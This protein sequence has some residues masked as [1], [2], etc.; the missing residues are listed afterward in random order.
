MKATACGAALVLAAVVSVSCASAPEQKALDA[1]SRDFYSKVRYIITREERNTFLSLRPS[2]QPEFIKQFW[3]RRDPTPG[4]EA[5]EFKDRYFQRIDDANRLFGGGG[6]PGWLQ[7]RGRVY[8][9]LGPADRRER[10][11]KGTDFLDRPSETWWYGNYPVVFVDQDRTDDY[12]L[13]SA[14]AQ[15]L[16][17]IGRV[18]EG[19][20]ARMSAP[21][22]APGMGPGMMPGGRLE[23]PP[24]PGFT[25]AAARNGNMTE[26]AVK[27]PYRSI[28][29]KAEGNGFR[30][31]I[32]LDMTVKNA[33][34]AVVW[35]TSE[36]FEIFLSRTEVMRLFEETY[37]MKVE[38]D[39]PPG[40]Y[41][42]TAVIVNATG[43]GRS[44]RNLDLDI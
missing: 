16:D 14:S 40:R 30:T 26:F 27:V 4:T 15:R 23:P 6:T 32:N 8:I 22:G 37:V 21:G 7:D 38:A 2:E 5:N 35:Q 31:V 3:L 11:L 25:V 10:N 18:R 28:W 42:L 12:R 9:I 41:R 44:V 24:G 34:G 29:L 33:G 19:S 36:D 17:E 13:T 1:D 43:G 39:I 20:L